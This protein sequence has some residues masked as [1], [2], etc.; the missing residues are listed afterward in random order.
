[1][2]AVMKSLAAVTL[3]RTVFLWAKLACNGRGDDT[4]ASVR[5]LGVDA[6]GPELGEITSVVKNVSGYA[7]EV[8]ALHEDVF[9]SHLA[10]LMVDYILE[11]D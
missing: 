4:T 11:R 8:V 1:M 10:D 7:L 6:F 2:A 3:S 9:R 5:V